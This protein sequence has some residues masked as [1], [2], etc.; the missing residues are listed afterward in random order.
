LIASEC[1]RIAIVL[2]KQNH[3][4]EEALSFARRAVE[5]FTHLKSPSLQWAHEM[6]AE[7]EEALKK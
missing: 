6:L 7:I 4:L 5:I 2:L 1:S 3:N